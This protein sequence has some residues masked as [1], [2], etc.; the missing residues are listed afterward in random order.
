MPITNGNSNGR[1]ITISGSTLTK[2]LASV[3]G[4]LLAVAL[5]VLSTFGGT[6]VDHGRRL[7]A[8]ETSIAVMEGTS[9]TSG[10]AFTLQNRMEARLEAQINIFRLEM[11]TRFDRLEARIDKTG[12]GS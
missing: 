1:N 3:N 9:F 12:G 8:S 2:I 5:Y 10:D 7:N 11:N 4:V 6:Q